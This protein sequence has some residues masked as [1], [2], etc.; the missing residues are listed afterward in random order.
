[1]N[2]LRFALRQLLKSPGFTAVAVLTLALGIGVNSAIFTVVNAVFLERLPY[3]DADRIAVIWETSVKRPGVSNVAGPSNFVRWKERATS[4]E[5]MAAYAETRANL[6][7]GGNPEELIAQNVTP[8]YFAVIGVS[9]ILG[10]AFTPEES[11]N[12]QSSVVI[13]SYE[14]WQRRF[15]LDQAIIGRTIQ[16]QGKPQ[17]VVGVMPPGVRLYLKAGSLVNKPVDFWWPYVLGP[18]AREARGRYLTVIG[19]LKPGVTIET[20]RNEMSSIYASVTQ[21]LPDFDTGW[22]TKVVPL[23]QELSGE[24][25]PA[26]L[27]LSGA[28]AFV[29]LIACANVA[30][31]LLAR[32]AARRHELAVRSALGATRGQIVKQLLTESSLLGIFG[33]LVSLLVAQWSLAL[34]EALSPIDLTALG[35]L[36]LNYPVLAFTG[37]ISI[38]TAVA[39]GL[40]SALEGSRADV[41]QALAQGGRQIGGGLRHR[42]LRHAFVIAEIALAVVL[43]I[44]AGLMLRSFASMR[45]VDPGFD[46]D[47]VLTMRMQLPRAKYPDDGAR[48][49]FFRELTARVAPLPGVQSVGAISYLPMAGLGAGTNLTIEG[50]PPPA[51]GQD[52]STAVTVCDNGFFRTLKIPLLR[53]RFFSEEE[54]QEKRNVVIINEALA[55]QYFPNQDALGKR[56]TINMLEKNVPTE[57]IG[58]VGN[59]HEVDLATPAKPLSYWPHPQ[60]AYSLMTLTV[61]T[62]ANPLGLAQPIEAQ[63]HGMDKD[64]PV[65]EVRTMEQWVAKSMAQIRFSSS[66]L[67]AFAGLALLLAA[68]GIYGVMSYAV[69]QRTSE[70]GVRLAVGAEGKDISRMIV[71]EGARLAAIG[72]TIGLVLAGAL[73]RTINSLLFQTTSADPLTFGAVVTVLGAFALIAS[74]LPARRAARVDPLLA[75]RAQ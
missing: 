26:L 33:G 52:K 13:L 10:R 39:C 63:I 38:V 30:N 61:R 16:L 17:T 11:T 29:L 1:M 32:G 36:S 65:S 42:N 24:I 50:E 19:R 67:M 64:Q 12:K 53:G 73:S 48:I 35:H 70:I 71:W 5:S 3:R 74:Y 55:Q 62:A 57:I 22:S 21:E 41:Q 6:T 56:V 31:L 37:A 14:L 15:G 58:V 68:I 28:V 8:D 27:L 69:S 51:P 66:L 23:R 18:E 34:L 49:R 2:D 54:M 25:R 59:T 4:F 43:L 47:N 40:A 72:L 46:P 9:P 75:L 7:D 44:G 45:Q 20:A 60:L